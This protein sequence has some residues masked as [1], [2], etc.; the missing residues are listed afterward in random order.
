MMSDV[1]RAARC[2]PGWCASPTRRSCKLLAEA[3][4]VSIEP[5]LPLSGAALLLAGYAP[6][7]RRSP[8]NVDRPA[9]AFGSALS[10]NR[11]GH[12]MTGIDDERSATPGA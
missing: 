2:A 12:S 7:R 9:A 4:A 10:S 1:L 11:H 6:C 8:V 3:S 5:R